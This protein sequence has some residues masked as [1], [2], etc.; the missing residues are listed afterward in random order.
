LGEH[1]RG[2]PEPANHARW[3]TARRSA[4]APLIGIAAVLLCASAAN[5]A[6]AI[7]SV[8][9]GDN[10]V[11]YPDAVVFGTGFGSTTNLAYPGYT[12][13]VYGNARH[14]CDTTPNPTAFRAGQNNAGG[15]ELIGLVK[16]GWTGTSFEIDL[17]STYRQCYDAWIDLSDQVAGVQ[18]VAARERTGRVVCS[19]AAERAAL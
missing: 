3:G 9:F 12:S 6:P 8:S 1:D 5:A 7:T 11:A 4:L 10:G 16:T 14:I 13:Y 18:I 2:G 17:G 19:R 15:G